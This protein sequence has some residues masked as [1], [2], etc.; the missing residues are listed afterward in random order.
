MHGAGEIKGIEEREILGKVQPYYLIKIPC[1]N[2]NVMV[3]VANATKLGVR[4]LTEP[5]K[6]KEILSSL[7]EQKPEEEIPWKDRLKLIMEKMKS[8]NIYDTAKIYKYLVERSK[9]KTLNTNEKALL[10]KVHK[11]LISEICMIENIRESE[12]EEFLIS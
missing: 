6:L 1:N 12:A 4:P 11:F 2:M 7:Q 10:S 5:S 9:E 8:G 3:P